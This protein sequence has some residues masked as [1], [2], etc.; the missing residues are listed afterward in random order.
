MHHLIESHHSEQAYVANN[1]KYNTCIVICTHMC[2][3]GEMN[4]A[5]VGTV[6]QVHATTTYYFCSAS[7]IGMQ[8]SANYKLYYAHSNVDAV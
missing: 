4:T 1:G 7:A 3:H 6:E 5:A 8:E 2:T